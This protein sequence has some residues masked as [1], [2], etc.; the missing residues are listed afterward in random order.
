MYPAAIP[1]T[2]VED[3]GT[4]AES[5]ASPNFRDRFLHARAT[6]ARGAPP[7]F[8]MSVDAAESR[9]R[10]RDTVRDRPG[11]P[12]ERRPPRKAARAP[13]VTLRGPRVP[14]RPQTRT[15]GYTGACPAAVFALH[16]VIVSVRQPREA[17]RIPDGAR[18]L[19]VRHRG[20]C[21]VPKAL[22]GLPPGALPLRNFSHFVVPDRI[23]GRRVHPADPQSCRAD[24]LMRG[25][26]TT[27]VVIAHRL[28]A[29]EDTGRIVVLDEGRVVQ[30]GRHDA[31]PAHDGPCRS[32]VRPGGE[33]E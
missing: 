19:G 8:G 13:L 10:R 15:T 4:P 21:S 25:P 1:E 2:A 31:S 32:S 22:R 30:A 28:T 26:G 24:T 5:E 11:G 29:V 16:G 14:V 27:L 23:D 33:G 12:A 18:D 9:L 3:T 17:R 7:E 6:G 20:V